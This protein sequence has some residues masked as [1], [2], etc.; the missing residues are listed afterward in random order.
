MQATVA[1]LGGLEITVSFDVSAADPE[2]GYMCDAVED[3]HIIEI[4]GRKLRKNEKADWLYRRIEATKGTQEKIIDA[5]YEAM[6]DAGS[7]T[8]DDY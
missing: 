2:V 3:W 6:N 5:C 1:I 7:R 8:F 4:A